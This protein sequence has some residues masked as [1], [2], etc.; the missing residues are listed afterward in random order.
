MTLTF[1]PKHDGGGYLADTEAGRYI[2]ARSVLGDWFATFNNRS[3]DR[4]G[5]PYRT[6]FLA[7]AAAQRHFEG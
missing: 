6:K 2:V 4:N 5:E 7:E 3:V 1:T